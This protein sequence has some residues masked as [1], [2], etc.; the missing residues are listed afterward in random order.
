MEQKMKTAIVI[1]ATG[2]V[3][4]AVTMQLLDDP[5]YEKVIVFARRSIGQRHSKLEE[6]LIDF[7][8]TDAW[9]AQV[10]GEVLF[11][12]LGTT[13][14]QAGSTAAQ[15]IVDYDFQYQFA[16]V[17]AAYG[18]PSYVLVSSVGADASSMLFYPKM[19]GQL[20][21]DV[22]QLGFQQVR[23][24]RPGPLHGPR[25]QARGGEGF[26]LKL[27]GALNSI[28]ILR[29]YRPISGEQ[30]ATVMRMVATLAPPKVRIL[31]PN[32]LFQQLEKR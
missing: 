5:D 6:H 14:K 28:G 9:K 21:R 22:Q 19:K 29:K 3:G 30:V 25:E 1:G 24:L 4:R 12:A 32:D 15:Y 31:E 7:A 17:A 26:G 18:V 20:D 16:K 11:S 2:L 8:E 10:K 27:I 13:R 23:I